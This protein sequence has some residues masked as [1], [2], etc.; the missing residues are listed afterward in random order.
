MKHRSLSIAFILLFV[1]CTV[2]LAQWTIIDDAYLTKPVHDALVN[3]MADRF[4][5]L[6]PKAGFSLS[7]TT[8][9]AAAIR[10]GPLHTL[11][12]ASA[13]EQ[14][15]LVIATPNGRVP[16]TTPEKESAIR[17]AYSISSY[18]SLFQKYA[19]VHLSVSPIP[20]R[21][22]K[23]II[24]G[25]DCPATEKSIYR[26]PPGVTTVNVTRVGKVPCAWAGA[27][28]SGTEQTVECKL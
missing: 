11:S 8:G 3:A 27:V 14:G 16:I 10:T 4:K 17:S 19:T 24:N 12:I 20:P 5:T 9:L 1:D 15:K 7:E 18:E 23:V 25:E 26:V 22:Y 21:D 6:G 13:G 28:L 2:A